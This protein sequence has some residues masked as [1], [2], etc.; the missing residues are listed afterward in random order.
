MNATIVLITYLVA[1]AIGSIIG[2]VIG[3]RKSK[4]PQYHS[5]LT[6]T[7]YNEYMAQS[8]QSASVAHGGG[9]LCPDKTLSEIISNG[10]KENKLVF[11]N[12]DF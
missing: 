4:Q 6:T 1:F 10:A 3:I 7:E 2:V 11:P 5:V 9:E 12:I 8:K